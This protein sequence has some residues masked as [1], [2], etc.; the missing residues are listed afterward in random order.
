[1]SNLKQLL[2]TVLVLCLIPTFVTAKINESRNLTTLNKCKDLSL[3]E[4]FIIPICAEEVAAIVAEKMGLEKYPTPVVKNMTQKEFN[5]SFFKD[6]LCH[7]EIK[8]T[9]AYFFLDENVINWGPQF[10]IDRLAHEI[11]HYFQKFLGYDMHSE[12]I[13]YEMEEQ[14]ASIQLWFRANYSHG[15]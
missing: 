9:Y 2:L 12:D 7:N 15:F 8:G 5:F 1:M 10:P 11:V 14:A 3:Y 4:D 6:T 13:Y